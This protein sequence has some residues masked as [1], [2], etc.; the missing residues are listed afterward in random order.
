MFSLCTGHVRLSIIESVL[1]DAGWT[2]SWRRA[3]GR[4]VR[5]SRN[6]KVTSPHSLVK[7]D[8]SK[9]TAH[10]ERHPTSRRHEWAKAREGV[11]VNAWRVFKLLPVV[12]F[13]T[14]CCLK[15]ENARRV[16]TVCD[17]DGSSRSGAFVLNLTASHTSRSLN[18]TCLSHR[19]RQQE[20]LTINILSNEPKIGTSLS[21][22]SR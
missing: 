15:E 9:T 8:T 14:Q 12:V 5:A 2:S 20:A 13:D 4:V 7:A 22:H 17:A 10:N 18:P 3:G 16:N 6:R 1:T 21:K 19:W 11:R